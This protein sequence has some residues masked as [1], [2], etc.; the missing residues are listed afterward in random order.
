MR[1]ASSRFR[2]LPFAPRPVT[3][4]LISSWL[5][6]V[7]AQ[8]CTTLRE[9]LTAVPLAY[10][11]ADVEVACLDYGLPS[12]FRAGLAQFC[13]VSAYAIRNL[14]LQHQFPSVPRWMF[15]SFPGNME[16]AS[17]VSGR[18]ARYNFCLSCL[19][20]SFRENNPAVIRAVW[21]LASVTHCHR[22]YRPLISRCPRCSAEDP[23][24]FPTRL[25]DPRVQCRK[26]GAHLPTSPQP[27]DHA[28]HMNFVLAI[29]RAY[30]AA[31]AG[32][33]PE[34]LGLE[35]TSARTFRELVEYF[36]FLFSSRLS[37]QSSHILARYFVDWDIAF[38]YFYTQV[39]VEAQLGAFTWEWRY[40]VMYSVA[41]AILGRPRGAETAYSADS[42]SLEA[43][44]F[45]DLLHFFSPARKL[46]IIKSSRVWPEA[47][48]VRLW[49][50]VKI[51][52][53]R[54]WGSPRSLRF[55]CQ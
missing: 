16:L 33:R 3:G 40:A 18:R 32:M 48:Q 27:F 1:R 4:E 26:C 15:L 5:L 28:P 41:T 14:E 13:R 29:E 20:E 21:S 34:A 47:L 31:I 6:R 35:E 24:R 43:F 45:R 2:C 11:K 50:A 9:L 49:L 8:N 44:P 10:P 23:L 52:E 39:V 36:V 42:E 51:L 53:G 25:R 38:R 19:N 17:R 55:K 37:W 7:A 22:H 46:E 12:E 30:L 54:A